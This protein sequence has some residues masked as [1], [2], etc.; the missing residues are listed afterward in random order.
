M[1]FKIHYESCILSLAQAFET[2][3]NE[4]SCNFCSHRAMNVPCYF[5]CCLYVESN[6]C[7]EHYCICHVPS[8][9]TDAELLGDSSTV[10]L[11]LMAEEI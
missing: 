3:Y 1:A 9:G 8:A 10:V 5:A 2:A 6:L 4:Y 7:G 11:M